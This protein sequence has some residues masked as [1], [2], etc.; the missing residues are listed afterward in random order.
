MKVGY[1]SARLYTEETPRMIPTK[2]LSKGKQ[3]KGRKI[4]L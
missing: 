2:A 4:K 1:M 3:R